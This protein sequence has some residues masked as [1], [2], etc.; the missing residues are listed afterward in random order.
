VE[1]NDG[2]IHESEPTE[3]L[4]PQEAEALEAYLKVL[5]EA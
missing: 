5:A 3:E 4:R 2:R 1:A